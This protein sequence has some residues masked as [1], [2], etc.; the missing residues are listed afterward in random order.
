MDIND[1]LVKLLSEL[2]FI[3]GG[4]GMVSQC[5]TIAEGLQAI[6]PES[7]RPFLVQAITRINQND[8]ITAERI[9]REQA[10]KLQPDSSMAK[11]FLGVA[12]HLQGRLGERDRTLQEVADSNDDE[13]AVRIATD[14]L[15]SP[16]PA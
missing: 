4:Y 12:L 1:D 8:A 10:L 15:G 13:D 2:A 14:L 5:D 11:A 16:A 7:E 3:A 9:L 6:R